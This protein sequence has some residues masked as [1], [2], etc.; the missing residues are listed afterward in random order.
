MNNILSIFML[1]AC[2]QAFAASAMKLES[3]PQAFVPAPYV[4]VEKIKGDLNGDGVSDAVLLIQDTDKTKFSKH[5]F[6]GE[7]DRNRRGIV[8]ALG[9]THGYQLVA[10]NLKCFSSDNEDGGVYYAPELSLSIVK[11]TLRIHYA[12]GR[13]GYWTYIF[14][15]QNSDFEL[16]GFDSSEDHGP[17]VERFI[18]INLLTQKMRVKHNVNTNARGGDE[19]F[20]ERWQNFTLTQPIKLSEIKDFDGFDV[21]DLIHTR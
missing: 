15:L 8:V 7:L 10:K 1:A 3:S 20:V 21:E 9:G 16:I 2:T 5:E 11:G 17:V 19:K 4:V 14:R 6:R 13:Y 12:H 18:S